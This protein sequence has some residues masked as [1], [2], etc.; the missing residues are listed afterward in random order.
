MVPHDQDRET[1][2]DAIKCAFLLLRPG[3]ARIAKSWCAGCV[4]C[5]CVCVCVCGAIVVGVGSL[6]WQHRVHQRRHQVPQHRE[7]DGRDG[8]GL[9]H[10]HR[11]RQPIG[12][13]SPRTHRY[14]YPTTFH[15]TFESHLTPLPHASHT[16]THTHVAR[17]PQATTLPSARVALRAST[18]PTCPPTTRASATRAST[19][20]RA[21]TW[22]SASPAR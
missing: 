21:S 19:T 20:R 18:R 12:R 8:Q 11:E 22:P 6:S 14:P 9:P 4:C 16:H 2:I 3:G 17:L 10:P 1:P 13:R 15:S 7:G 5:M